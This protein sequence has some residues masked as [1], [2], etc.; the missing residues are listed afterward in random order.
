V[1]KKTEKPKQN[2]RK[3]RTVK[4]NRLN[5]LEY[6]KKPTGSVWFQFHKPETKKPNQTE[7]NKKV[8][9][10]RNQTH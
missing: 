2:N 7:I 6:L 8:E 9:P 5:L 1:S 4:K 10:N 3:N